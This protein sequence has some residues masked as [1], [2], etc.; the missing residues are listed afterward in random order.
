MPLCQ[1]GRE[2]QP[3]YRLFDR[4]FANLVGNCRG[5]RQ[6]ISADSEAGLQKNGK[7]LAPTFKP[8]LWFGLKSFR[9]RPADLV[10]RMLRTRGQYSGWDYL[11]LLVYMGDH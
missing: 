9:V 2:N 8:G 7:P 5:A 1:V 10:I 4:H 6:L 3:F 11:F